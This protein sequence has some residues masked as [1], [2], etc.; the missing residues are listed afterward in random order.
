[1]GDTYPYPID[2]AKLLVSPAGLTVDSAL[3]KA[4]GA[5]AETGSQKY[6]A[7]GLQKG[8]KLEARLT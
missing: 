2:S 5:D 6:V 8:T 7:A 4:A 1:L 3:F